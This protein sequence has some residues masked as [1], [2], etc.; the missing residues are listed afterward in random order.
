MLNGNE[1]NR[2]RRV[3]TL[4]RNPIVRDDNGRPSTDRE[5]HFLLQLTNLLGRDD[6][7]HKISIIFETY[8]MHV[9]PLSP[10]RKAARK[11]L[12]GQEVQL[13]NSIFGI[14]LGTIRQISVLV[15]TGYHETT[16][17][18]PNSVLTQGS[19]PHRAVAW[20]GVIKPIFRMHPLEVRTRCRKRCDCNSDCKHG[21]PPSIQPMRSS[22]HHGS[23]TVIFAGETLPMPRT[24]GRYMSSTSGGGTT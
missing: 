5:N 12:V 11:L 8:F 22:R 10:I 23:T 3:V 19:E 9:S 20:N 15:G 17:E 18:R 2:I 6:C 24:A 21:S 4:N 13:Q 1:R 16:A 7:L 14:R